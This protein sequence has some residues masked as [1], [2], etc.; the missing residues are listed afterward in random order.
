MDEALRLIAMGLKKAEKQE[1]GTFEAKI[2]EEEPEK[3]GIK[4][5]MSLLSWMDWN[6]CNIISAV[7]YEDGI[8]QIG[9]FDTSADVIDAV[10]GKTVPAEG[11]YLKSMGTKY[12]AEYLLQTAADI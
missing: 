8:L 7:K 3:Q 11:W 1:D 6:G 5:T 4:D 2:A 9:F 10:Q 12:T